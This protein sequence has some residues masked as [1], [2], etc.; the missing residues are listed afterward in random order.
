MS[1]T[2]RVA[3]CLVI[4]R[5]GILFY[6]PRPCVCL[7]VWQAGSL[8]CM[9]RAGICLVNRREGSLYYT[10]RDVF[11]LVLIWWGVFPTR[12]VQITVSSRIGGKFVL[13]DPSWNMCVRSASSFRRWGVSLTR[14]V[15][16]TVCSFV[17]QGVLSDTHLAVIF[18]V[19]R[20]RRSVGGEFLLHAP[21][22]K[23][24]GLS[25]GRKSI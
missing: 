15:L 3:I 9:P 4:G 11:Y 19:V 18:L 21:F 5:V 13:H 1:Y 8:Y 22:W 12:P 6:T 23:L 25:S 17:E 16:E 24:S 2:P 14:P 10:A 20:P 7:I